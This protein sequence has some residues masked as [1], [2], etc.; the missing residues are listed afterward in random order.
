MRA[1]ELTPEHPLERIADLADRAER[2]GFDTV[3][4]ASHYFNRDPF[5]ALDRIAAATDDVRLGP[6]AANPYDAHPVT[7]A[8]RV[9]TIQEVSDGRAVFGIGPGDRSTLSALG[10][11]RDRPLRRVLETFSAARDLWAG[12]AVDA[13]GTF[14]AAGA[15]LEYE[16]PG[17]IPVYVAAQGPGMLGM[18]AKHAD[19]VL[20]NGSHPDDVAWAAQQVADG[21]AERPAERGDFEFTAY[22]SVSVAEEEAAAREAARPP[23]AFIAGGAAPPVLERHGLD[24]ERA[25][26]IGAAIENGAYREAFGLVTD[27]FV[28]A[29]SVTGTPT[30]V[31][32][33]LEKLLE[34]ADGVVVGAPLGPD[35][36][37]AVE[38]AG[39]ALS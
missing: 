35:L 3:F 22:A 23:V 18:S 19:G 15:E 9:A 33:Q 10:V 16:V 27:E 6:A 5:V 17:T 11:E 8:S 25:G 30:Q 14:R 38:L 32:R 21:L 31:E 29:F 13:D 7:L 28:D 36:E 20:F 37:R 1:I 26:E 2:E 24:R 39:A 12:E 4:A 34:Y